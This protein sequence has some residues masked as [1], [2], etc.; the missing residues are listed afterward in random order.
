MKFGTVIADSLGYLHSSF[1]VHHLSTLV[2]PTGQIQTY[3]YKNSA[4]LWHRNA[5]PLSSDSLGHGEFKGYGIMIL[6]SAL[7]EVFFSFCNLGG[8]L[9]VESEAISQQ[10]YL[11]T[12]ADG[13][14]S[15]WLS[16]IAKR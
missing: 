11:G 15:F 14:E 10:I 6:I 4:T 5:V 2:P 13:P 9:K 7:L 3:I 8:I 1:G 12:S 16:S